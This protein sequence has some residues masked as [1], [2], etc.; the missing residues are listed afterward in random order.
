MTDRFHLGVSLG[1]E[2]ESATT[3]RF[4]E[5]DHC[6]HLAMLATD[7]GSGT[8]ASVSPVHCLCPKWWELKLSVQPRL[9]LGL[10]K[11][12]VPSP[13]IILCFLVLTEA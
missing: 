1:I 12:L 8:V 5:K 13:R 3:A 10:F 6:N 2:K 11:A 9:V 7:A 4:G